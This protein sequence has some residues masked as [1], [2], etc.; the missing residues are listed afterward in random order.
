MIKYKLEKKAIIIEGKHISLEN[1]VK[2]VL[3]INDILIVLLNYDEKVVDNEPNIIAFSSKGKQIWEIEALKDSSNKYIDIVEEKQKLVA[4]D[5]NHFKNVVNEENG[6]VVKLKIM[7]L[8]DIDDDSKTLLTKNNY[9]QLGILI[10]IA[11][12]LLK[13]FMN[14]LV[15][16]TP[17]NVN[18]NSNT[19]NEVSSSKQPIQQVETSSSSSTKPS[20]APEINNDNIDELVQNQIIK[21]MENQG[22][23]NIFEYVEQQEN[24]SSKVESSQSQNTPTEEEPDIIDGIFGLID[25][26]FD[27][28]SNNEPV[29]IDDVNKAEVNTC[30]Y[31]KALAIN[32]IKVDIAGEE[33]VVKLISIKEDKSSYAIIDKVLS[34]NQKLY[35]EYDSK[36]KEKDGTLLAYVYINEDKDMDSMLNYYLI[37]NGH[38]TFEIQS[39]NIKHNYLMQKK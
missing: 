38:A 39:P 28:F 31:I 26:M 7:P 25:G 2:K 30:T 1:G 16:E 33:Y 29:S 37:K 32:K 6:E 3:E 36:K 24:S 22:A 27:A 11:F 15:I 13:G 23:D 10:V 21:D 19:T 14:L 5:V 8:K 35:L 18:D 12:F 4:I 34:E 9:I 17:T 20:T